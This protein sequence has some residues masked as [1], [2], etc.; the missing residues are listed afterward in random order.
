VKTAAIISKHVDAPT[1]ARNP[2]L[3]MS[4]ET[5]WISYVLWLAGE[6]RRGR[7]QHPHSISQH[8]WNQQVQRANQFNRIK[9]NF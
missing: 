6:A 7:C 1:H 4:N 8:L 2:H 3:F 9:Y 5:N